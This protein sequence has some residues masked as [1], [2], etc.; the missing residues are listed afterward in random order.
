V[1]DLINPNK[2]GE[3]VYQRHLAGRERT[4]SE[5]ELLEIFSCYPD[6][7]RKPIIVTPHGIS[8]GFDPERLEA[9]WEKEQRIGGEP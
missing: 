5:Q 7:L 4:V 2:V 6:L 9:L 3:D 8:V 1:R